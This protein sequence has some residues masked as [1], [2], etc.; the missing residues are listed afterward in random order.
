MVCSNQNDNGKRFK[1]RWYYPPKVVIK[2]YYVKILEQKKKK[3]KKLT[4]IISR[5]C[6]SL[7]KDGQ[8]YDVRVKLTNIQ[9]KRLKSAG[10]NKTGKTL[11]I[12]Q[13]IFQYEKLPHKSLLITE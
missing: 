5:K 4:K 11:T 10:E 9:L 8:L 1:A 3:K 6:N 12:V 13:K 7:T 2:N